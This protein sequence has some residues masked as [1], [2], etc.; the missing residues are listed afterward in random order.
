[1]PVIFRELVTLFLP[2]W[3]LNWMPMCHLF[4]GFVRTLPSG[5][6]VLAAMNSY[7][8]M[9]RERWGVDIWTEHDRA[10][11]GAGTLGPFASRRGQ[12]VKHCLPI[13]AMGETLTSLS[14]LGSLVRWVW[15]LRCVCSRLCSQLHVLA[16]RA[17]PGPGGRLPGKEAAQSSEGHFWCLV[18]ARPAP[19]ALIRAW[20]ESAA[21]IRLQWA[22]EWGWLVLLLL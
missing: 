5:S 7:Y 13:R 12:W 2:P 20:A 9:D 6:Y 15:K 1:M 16:S 18:D 10:G 14:P 17:K 4:F 21:W 11:Y 22:A 19:S 3:D 8:L